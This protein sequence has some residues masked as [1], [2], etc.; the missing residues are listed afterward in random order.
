MKNKRT[1]LGV[2]G[3]TLAEMAIAVTVASF[4][5]LCVGVVVVSGTR[6]CGK[7][8]IDCDLGR[9]ATVALRFIE[10]KVR[11]KASTEVAIN[12]DGDMLTI[13]PESA[14]A[15]YFH[16]DG[17]D[18]LYSDANGLSNVVVSDAVQDLHFEFVDDGSPEVDLVSVA[19]LLTREGK[20]VA[21]ASLIKLRN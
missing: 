2:A 3:T 6:I 16:T 18:L 4:L 15:G 21:T 7:A 10:N 5:I 9:D 14:N 17:G 13:D 11:Q 12:S 19:L 20:D 8:R 1:R